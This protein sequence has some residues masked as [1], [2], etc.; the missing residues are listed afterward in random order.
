MA[1][2]PGHPYRTL[3]AAASISGKTNSLFNLINHQQDIDKV[4]LYARD[5]HEAKHQFLIIK[6]EDGGTK[7][8]KSFIEYTNNIVDIY[9][10]IQDCNQNVKH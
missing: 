9:R 7:H 10:N 4:Y 3:I 6:R 5:L 8:F 1:T 2:V